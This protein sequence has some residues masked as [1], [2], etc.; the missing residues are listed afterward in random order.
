MNTSRQRGGKNPM[1]NELFSLGLPPDIAQ[2]YDGILD[3]LPQEVWLKLTRVPAE[4][5]HLRSYW[6]EFDER[7]STHMQAS[8]CG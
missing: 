8:E 5:I 6:L 1:S 3:G 4:P 7:P 2:R